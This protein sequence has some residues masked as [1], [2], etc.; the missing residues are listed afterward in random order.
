MTACNWKTKAQEG[1]SFSLPFMTEVW[2]QAD[3]IT[4]RASQKQGTR[5]ERQG[6]WEREQGLTKGQH[7]EAR[8]APSLS[9]SLG[10]AY[11]LN[12]LKHPKGA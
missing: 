4:G 2:K 6:S 1:G 12:L 7:D 3:T 5:A 10:E 11:A 9:P 8:L